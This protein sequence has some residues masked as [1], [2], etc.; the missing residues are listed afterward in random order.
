[1]D[2]S[3]TLQ[4]GVGFDLSNGGVFRV[5]AGASIFVS[6]AT[7]T[8]ASILSTGGTGAQNHDQVEVGA[9]ATLKTSAGIDMQG[10]YD[11]FRVDGSSAN[12]IDTVGGNLTIDNGTMIV[13]ADEAAGAFTT[14][15]VLGDFSFNQGTLMMDVAGGASPGYDQVLVSGT[16]YLSHIGTTLMV[17]NT[18]GQAPV[19]GLYYPLVRASR[20]VGFVTGFQT[21]TPYNTPPAAWNEVLYNAG[22]FDIW[23]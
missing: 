17:V 5:D 18:N 4:V 8:R 2:T 15:N 12:A 16:F 7:A 23:A 13:G 6:G 11:L 19:P 21:V 10:A 22:E 20:A 3:G 14:L 1:V 9:G